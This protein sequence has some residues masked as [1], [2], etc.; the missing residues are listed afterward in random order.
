MYVFL[1]PSFFFFANNSDLDALKINLAQ[2]CE[3]A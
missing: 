3:R 1:Q 2:T